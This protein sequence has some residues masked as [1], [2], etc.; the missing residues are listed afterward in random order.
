M[1]HNTGS[2]AWRIPPTARRSPK[3]NRCP[4]I[5]HAA[6]PE[7]HVSV[8]HHSSWRTET[9]DMGLSSGTIGIRRAEASSRTS[10]YNIKRFI[11]FERKAIT[12]HPRDV[13]YLLNP[14]KTSTKAKNPQKHTFQSL[15]AGKHANLTKKSILRSIQFHDK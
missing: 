2:E 8:P 15:I 11:F 1:R 13:K 7:G 10:V 9:S 5:S 14:A 3:A 6:M 12:G 4:A